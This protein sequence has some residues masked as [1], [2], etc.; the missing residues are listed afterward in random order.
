LLIVVP[1]PSLSLPVSSLPPQ[2]HA[3][4]AWLWW[5]LAWLC[6]NDTV[7]QPHCQAKRHRHGANLDATTALPS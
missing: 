5:W 4:A 1:P 7:L 2:R 6:P 3:V